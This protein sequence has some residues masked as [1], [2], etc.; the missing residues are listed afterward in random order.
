MAI[1]DATDKFKRAEKLHIAEKM[2][3]FDCIS[4][5]RAQHIV[6]TNERIIAIEDVYKEINFNTQQYKIITDEEE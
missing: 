5:A 3:E 2:A 6:G 4:N 1:I